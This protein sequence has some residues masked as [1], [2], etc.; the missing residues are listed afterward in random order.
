MSKRPD[1]ASAA[2][3]MLSNFLT[4]HF[5][6]GTGNDERPQTASAFAIKSGLSAS[7]ISEWRNRKGGLPSL[8]SLETIERCFFPGQA[9]RDNDPA[10]LEWQEVRRAISRHHLP[11]EPNPDEKRFSLRQAW[12]F[13]TR[14][15]SQR[16]TPLARSGPGTIGAGV[17]HRQQIDARLTQ[18]RFIL[19][20]P[21]WFVHA[22][23]QDDFLRARY[24]LH[25][26]VDFSGSAELSHFYDS[27]PMA[28]FRDMVAHHSNAHAQFILDTLRERPTYPPYNKKKVGLCGYQQSQ[29]S[30]GDEG[31]YLDLRFYETDYHTHRVMRRVFHDIASS[32]PQLFRGDTDLYGAIPYLAY[33]TTSFGVNVLVTTQEERG[34]R[35]YMSRLS[36]SQGNINQQNRWHVTVNEGVNLDDFR[37]SA[38]DI[39]AVVDRALM[40]EI[41]A[42]IDEVRGETIYLQ[43]G[44]EQRNFEP[45]I[46]CIVHLS[47]D[48][49]A[50]YRCKQ[51][52]AR[53][54]RRE[55]REVR[56]FP[57]SE[58]GIIQLLLDDPAGVEG[59]TSY[60]L[61]ILDSVLV[62][63]LAPRLTP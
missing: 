1:A 61:N 5:G 35:F 4:K 29:R 31:I 23:Q 42:V 14:S 49:E 50:L 27:V 40:E 47:S 18:L 48:R 19:P 44:I 37:D 57:F 21:E 55:F 63:G 12:D 53:D 26:P 46:S 36:S 51:H 22:T 25:G 39:G 38:M 45:F 7:R 59:F 17:L 2:S 24:D 52:M 8:G 6:L 30:G 62:R 3:E 15:V 16:V 58:Q 9:T 10:Y 28:G 13:L 43:F 11:S 32:N 34:K 41:G 60:C 20:M 54:D 56:D 33:F